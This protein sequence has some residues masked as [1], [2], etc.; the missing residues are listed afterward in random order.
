MPAAATVFALIK[1]KTQ[2]PRLVIVKQ[3]RPPLGK[4]TVELCAGLVD[5]GQ[6]PITHTQG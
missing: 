4:F 5:P 1:S 6:C 2:E 3:F